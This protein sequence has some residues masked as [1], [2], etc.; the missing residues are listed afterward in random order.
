MKKQ[1][2]N[3]KVFF[4]ISA[5]LIIALLVGS[6]ILN[7]SANKSVKEDVT[8]AT[9]SPK[10]DGT[11]TNIR[12]CP[13]PPWCDSNVCNNITDEKTCKSKGEM[14]SVQNVNNTC[15][16]CDNKSYDP[17]IGPSSSAPSPSPLGAPIYRN[18]DDGRVVSCNAGTQRCNQS[19]LQQMC[20]IQKPNVLGGKMRVY[21]GDGRFKEC[22]AGTFGCTQENLQDACNQ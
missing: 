12:C 7:T 6:A 16:K 4:A 10:D 18:C 15:K 13:K 8:P 1:N 19:Y 2:Q 11:E 17:A 22:S 14:C 21:C 3:Y 20:R 9:P 5:I